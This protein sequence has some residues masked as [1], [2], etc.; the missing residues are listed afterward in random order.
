MS[1]LLGLMEGFWAVLGLCILHLVVFLLMIW[2]SRTQI[3]EFKVK[4]VKE[5]ATYLQ[6]NGAAQDEVKTEKMSS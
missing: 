2:V 1:S 3:K 6:E 4:E 5:M